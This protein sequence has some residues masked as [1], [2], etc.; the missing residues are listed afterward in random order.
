MTNGITPRRWFTHAN[1]ALAALVCEAI[2][3]NVL[4]DLECIKAISRRFADDRETHA[5]Q[6]RRA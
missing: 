4:D 2:G 6:V 3:E 5:P 1:P